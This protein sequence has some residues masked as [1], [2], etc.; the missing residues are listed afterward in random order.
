VTGS[1]GGIAESSA[2]PDKFALGLFGQAYY[3]VLLTVPFL[4]A[5]RHALTR[6]VGAWCEKAAGKALQ[7]PLGEAGSASHQGESR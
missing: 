3:L 1:I 6:L 2:R 4:G 5:R 7:E